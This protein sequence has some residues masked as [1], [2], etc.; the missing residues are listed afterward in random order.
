MGDIKIESVYPLTAMQQGIFF[1]SQLNEG[2]KA[3]FIQNVFHMTGYVDTGQMR[4]SLE[5]LSIKYD[6]LR[7][8]FMMSKKEEKPLQFVRQKQ[9]IELQEFNCKIIS[10]EHA[11]QEVERIAKADIERGFD[12]L[13]DSMVRLKVIHISGRECFLIWSAH[14]IIIDGWCS[15]IIMKEFLDF[16]NCL[17]DGNSRLKLMSRVKNQKSKIAPFSEYVKWQMSQDNEAG[18]G[19]WKQYLE[20]YNETAVIPPM[21]IAEKHKEKMSE[22]NISLDNRLTSGLLKVANG[23]KVTVSNIAEMIWGIVLMKYCRLDDVVFGKV[24]SGR[25]ADIKGIEEAVGIYVN[26]VPERIKIGKDST[27]YTVLKRI[28]EDYYKGSNY[29]YCSLAEVQASSELKNQLIGSIFTFEN[30]YGSTDVF[31]NAEHFSVCLHSYREETNYEIS[32]K[33]DLTDT[34]NFNILYNPSVYAEEEIDLIG[35]RIIVIAENMVSN[36]H[37]IICNINLLQTVEEEQIL[38]TFNSKMVDYGAD[39]TIST[40]FEKIVIENEEKIALVCGEKRIT[41]RRLNEKANSLASCLIR[42]GVVQG[43]VIAVFAERKMETL[44]AFIAIQKLGGIYLPLDVSQPKRRIELILEDAKPN[45]MLTI[46]RQV[47]YEGNKVDICDEKIYGQSITN[48]K[49]RNNRDSFSYVIYTSGTT[50]KPKGVLLTHRGVVNL[51]YFFRTE[52]QIGCHDKV[53]QFANYVF[54]AS[55]WEFTMALLTG[56]SLHILPKNVIEDPT[57]CGEYLKNNE[58]T[59][60]TLPPLYCKQLDLPSMRLIITAGSSADESLVSMVKEKGQYVNAYGPTEDTVCTTYYKYEEIGSSVKRVPIGKPI[61]NHQVYIMQGKRLCPVGMPGELRI[62]GCGVAQMYLNRQQLTEQKFIDNPYGKGKMYCSGDLARWLPDGSIDFMG[63]MDE[64]V[65]I[66]GFRIELEEIS[67]VLMSFDKIREAAAI[68]HENNVGSKYICAFYSSDERVIAENLKEEL[69]SYLPE[70]MMPAVF[71]QVDEIPL[72]SSG[73]V[74]SKKL[75]DVQFVSDQEKKRPITKKEEKLEKIFCEILGEETVDV[76]ASFFEIGGESILAMK[77]VTMIEKEFEFKVSI[78]DIFKYSTVRELAEIIVINSQKD[79]ISNLEQKIK[80]LLGTSCKEVRVIKRK[81][82]Y[83][84]LIDNEITEEYKC[85]IMKK[86]SE[87]YP[88]PRFIFESSSFEQLNADQQTDSIE[89]IADE[90]IKRKDVHMQ[91]GLIED[92]IEKINEYRKNLLIQKERGNGELSLIQKL[93]Y[94]IGIRSSCGYFEINGLYDVSE[95]E[96]A[97]RQ[98]LNEQ[99]LL[100]STIQCTNKGSG[101]KEYAISDKWRLPYFNISDYC[102]KEKHLLIQK[103]K[104]T[105]DLYCKEEMYRGDEVNHSAILL[106]VEENKYFFILPCS[107]LVFDGFSNVILK[108]HIMEYLKNSQNN[109]CVQRYQECMTQNR[110]SQKLVCDELSKKF[111]M[112]KFKKAVD[113]FSDYVKNLNMTAIDY[114]HHFM[115]TEMENISLIKKKINEKVFSGIMDFLF[116]NT[117]VP[118]YVVQAG[119]NNKDSLECIGVFLDLLPVIYCGFSENRFANN[120]SSQMEYIRE[121]EA[122]VISAIGANILLEKESKMIKYPIIYNNLLMYELEEVFDINISSIEYTNR[123]VN[124]SMAN[125]ELCISSMCEVGKEQE[126]KGLMRDIINKIVEET[127]VSG[128]EYYKCG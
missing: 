64:Q 123:M 98:V 94:K 27:F 62:C 83:L 120:I 82:G 56:A 109:Q 112:Q 30:F 79:D 105:S 57:V 11:L 41:Y 51:G 77:L 5:L 113:S 23:C 55:I 103:I 54:D 92:L 78:S 117:S 69:A 81:D 26:I 73:K 4:T 97:W 101:I 115:N 71:V 63:R 72:N 16:Y 14:H 102:K 108:N 9:V 19:Y 119:R 22:Y 13:K 3:Y 18:I 20:G 2:T 38:K 125:E 31:N 15:V 49:N 116:P 32:V 21:K 36:V 58:I 43:D 6:A 24:V 128:E 106:K 122:N 107:H 74:D 90:I 126:L 52:F 66:R 65:K 87:K 70:Y 42:E 44:I 110:L 61:L 100:R 86:I 84:L 124:I 93:V 68:V 39:E 127:N 34:L 91:E 114:R 104:D 7:T 59:I 75:L 28:S 88:I 45:I 96:S 89:M 60:I 95:I 48:P 40:L 33:V 12:F 53:A 85:Q 99:S 67:N 50:G 121:H 8:G 76:E 10:N 1:E 46:G 25:N 35:K 80:E 118:V 37:Q 29:E 17:C 111:E 47:F